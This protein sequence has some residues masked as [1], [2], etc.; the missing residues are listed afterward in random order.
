MTEQHNLL[1][2]CLIWLIIDPYGGSD[3]PNTRIRFTFPSPER[4]FLQHTVL[5]WN[6]RWKYI[7]KAHELN[8]IRRVY[9][10]MT[11]YVSQCPRAAYFN[12]Y[13]D[14]GRNQGSK[15]GPRLW[16]VLSYTSQRSFVI[17]ELANQR[18]IIINT[19]G[20]W[21]CMNWSR[22]YIWWNQLS[23]RQ[24][25]RHTWFPSWCIPLYGSCGGQSVEAEWEP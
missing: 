25:E 6:G 5:G 15:W 21:N 13:I 4:E 12:W 9:E 16:G 24:K 8:W 17:I 18:K 23:N 10:Q 19:H 1:T 7:R 20:R 2:S 3:E 11:P 14:L 22:C